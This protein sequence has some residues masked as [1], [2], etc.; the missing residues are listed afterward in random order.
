MSINVLLVELL[1]MRNLGLRSHST[2]GVYF[3]T[4]PPSHRPGRLGARNVKFVNIPQFFLIIVSP[5]S[6]TTSMGRL[7]SSTVSLGMALNIASFQLFMMHLFLQHNLQPGLSSKAR[8]EILVTVKKQNA[9]VNST[10]I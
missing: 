4:L 2:V 5:V 1:G 9:L 6:C 3:I 8:T 7:S 10:T